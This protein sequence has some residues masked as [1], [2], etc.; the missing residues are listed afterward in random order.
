MQK[1]ASFH[2]CIT[3]LHINND[4]ADNFADSLRKSVILVKQEDNP[5]L[6]GTVAI[7]GMAQQ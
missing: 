4:L 1:P 5:E 3:K 2:I 7:Y 6:K